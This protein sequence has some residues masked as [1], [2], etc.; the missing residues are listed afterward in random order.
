MRLG[1]TIFG[2]FC[3]GLGALAAGGATAGK[4]LGVPELDVPQAAAAPVIDGR[5]DDLCWRGAAVIPGLKP[6]R[7]EDTQGKI[8]RIPTTV[9]VLWDAEFLYVG[10][11]CVDA[12]V[13]TSGSLRHDADL[14]KE[15]VC[16]VFLDGKGDGRQQVEIQVAPSGVNTDVLYVY[17]G[18]PEHTPEWRLTPKFV[19]RERWLLREWEMAGLRT[20][21]ARL[22]REGKAAGWSVELAIPA[23]AVVK[24]L[25]LKQ[26]EPLEIRANFMRYD[27]QPD[28]ATGERRILHMNW[29]PVLFGCPHISPAAM[30]RLRL[31]PGR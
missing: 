26:F 7:G 31:R 1:I 17:S 27:W 11:E 10:F 24:R 6:A 19:E 25:G 15:D 8:A 2:C 20:A 14:Y 22:Q 28:P 5:L 21:G 3:F 30:G 12:E 4:P 18:E 9:R 16:E 29:A 13:Y 23:A